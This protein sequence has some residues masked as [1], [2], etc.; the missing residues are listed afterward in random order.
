MKAVMTLYEHP[1][2]PSPFAAR[3][4]ASRPVL[5]VRPADLQEGSLPAPALAWARSAGFKAEAGAVL[6]VP[7]ASGEL[8]CALFGLGAEPGDSPFIAGKLSP[9][10]PAGDW[11]VEASG[12][13]AE[14]FALGFGLGSYS[15]GRYRPDKSRWEKRR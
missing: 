11:H 3:T 14:Q 4:D 9:L 13:S 8:D 1:D 12:L 15:F 7:S 2:P 5:A 10:L 6:L